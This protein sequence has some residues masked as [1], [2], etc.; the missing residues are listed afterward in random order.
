MRIAYLLSLFT[1]LFWNTDTLADCRP[2]GTFPAFRNDTVDFYIDT[3]DG[4]CGLNFNLRGQD[5]VTL[6]SLKLV[7]QPM[8]GAVAISED[9]S[10]SYWAFKAYQGKDKF[11]I[12][13]CAV[14]NGQLGCSVATASVNITSPSQSNLT[15]EMLQ[16]SAQ[17]QK[18][19]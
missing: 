13:I 17:Q 19:K 16:R 3:D 4:A 9:F 5:S 14:R 7:A 8:H 12:E 6:Q 18:K 15:P 11:S 1:L 2:Y 10:F